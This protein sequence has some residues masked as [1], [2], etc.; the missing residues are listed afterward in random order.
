MRLLYALALLLAAAP[1]WAQDP[2]DLPFTL[3]LVEVEV[4]NMPG[5][6]SF[7]WAEHDGRWLFVTGRTD[8]LHAV[9]TNLEPDPFPDDQA[10]DAVWVVDPV[11]DEVWS[12]SL[13]ELPDALADPLRVTNAQHAHAGETLYVVGGYG[14][15]AA[16]GDKIT[17]P[18][19]TAIDVPGMIEAVTTG[20]ALAPHLRQTE[21]AFL[22]VTG[23]EMRPFLGQYALIGGHRFD[24]EY[25]LDGTGFTQEYTERIL[26]FEIEDDGTSLD[27]TEWF[28]LESGDED[29]PLHRRDL[30]AAPSFYRYLP[31]DAEDPNDFS[32][33]E[34]WGLYGGVFRPDADLPYRSPLYLGFSDTPEF[35]PHEFEQ[36]FGHYTAPTLPLWD[37]AD[38]TMHTAFFGGMSEFYFDEE[39]GEV[40]RDPLVPFTD[41]V[42][43]LTSELTEDGA[44]FET[45]MP[46]QMPG[47][48][49]TNAALIP[50]AGVPRSDLGIVRLREVEGRTLVGHIVGG[51]VSTG[52]H[53]GWYGMTDEQTGASDRL[54]EVYL[55]PRFGSAAEPGTEPATVTFE[56]IYPNPFRSEATVAF[57]LDRPA[58]VA[59]EVYD[60]MGRRVAVLHEGPLG[61]QRHAFAFRPGALPAGVYTVRV[62]GA[63]VHATRSVVRVR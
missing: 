29:R 22:A 42:V 12:R 61:V 56:P 33:G 58:D 34:G 30:T 50:A 57:V 41:D 8:G 39:T 23:G 4:T 10:N 5:L 32:I 45:V 16:T 38:S 11:A 44:T 48:L 35:F 55:T 28:A 59:V 27:V 40:V 31:V 20:G 51:I 13:D 43:T 19:L 63:G 1:A 15:V 62:H 17:F 2:A 54:F 9:N 21:E 47:L 26:L 3:E 24:G 53:P 7:A 14:A 25:T 36:Q 46:F 18:T 52:L 60:V 49:G 6:H 37:A